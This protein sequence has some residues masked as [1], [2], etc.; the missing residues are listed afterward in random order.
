MSDTPIYDSVGQ[1]VT[2]K[3]RDEIIADIN[4]KYGTPP[5]LDVNSLYPAVMYPDVE[6]LS[7]AELHGAYAVDETASP[8]W[9][10]IA[11]RKWAY[12]VA[13]ALLSILSVWQGVEA[14]TTESWTSLLV[15]VLNLP[16]IGQAALARANVR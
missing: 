11:R 16:L 14:V 3:T 8:K 13:I 6:T 12:N 2:G 1:P 9:F 4:A 15:A 7:D 5:L 10:T